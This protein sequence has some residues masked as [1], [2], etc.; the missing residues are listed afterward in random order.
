[1][2]HSDDSSAPTS[3]LSG[4][5]FQATTQDEESVEQMINLLDIQDGMPAA[6]RLRDWAIERAA[7]QPGGQ[8]VDLGSGTGTMCRELAALVAPRGSSGTG[9]VT[10]IEPN[11]QLR[12]IAENRALSDGVPNVSFVHGLAGALPFDDASVDLVWCE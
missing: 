9:W 7:V 11:V 1:M 8:V 3:H 12:A 5:L 2:A 6:R 4:A 10:G